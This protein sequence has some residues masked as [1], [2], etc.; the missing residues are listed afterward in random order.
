MHS[1]HFNAIRQAK[2]LTEELVVGVISEEQIKLYKGP[3][4]M[5]IE[6]RVS[7]ASACKWADQIVVVDE[8][9]PT[10]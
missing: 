1:G 9:N 8:Y 3:S 7:L 5:S 4:I 2:E 6:E 10:L